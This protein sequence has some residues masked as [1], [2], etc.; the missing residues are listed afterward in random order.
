MRFPFNSHSLPPAPYNH[1]PMSP[2]MKKGRLLS[3]L[4]QTQAHAPIQ[5]QS[6]PNL[7]HWLQQTQKVIKVVQTV[8]PLVQQYGPIVKQLPELF[9]LL[10]TMQTNVDQTKTND[11][12]TNDTKKSETN[13]LTTT[14]TIQLPT[15]TSLQM[16]TEQEVKKE[17]IPKLYI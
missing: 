4:F 13:Q 10:S 1:S 5:T 2:F 6:L 17:S 14:P 15:T 12:A 8:G 7:L 11:T 9:K 16:T 3:S